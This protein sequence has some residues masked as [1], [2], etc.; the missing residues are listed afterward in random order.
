MGGVSMLAGEMPSGDMTG[1]S[2]GTLGEMPSGDMTGKS[3]GT[4]GEMPSGDMTGE[5]FETLGEMPSGDMTGKSSFCRKTGS[6]PT[7]RCRLS[8]LVGQNEVIELHHKLTSLVD[9][10]AAH[11]V[12]RLK[13]RLRPH[14]LREQGGDR[15]ANY[16]RSLSRPGRARAAKLIACPGGSGLALDCVRPSAFRRPPQG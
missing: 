12:D 11:H 2:S 10:H 1:K 16:E 3:S 15:C 14:H 4:L 9:L 5:T 8:V 7:Q 13:Q 6:G